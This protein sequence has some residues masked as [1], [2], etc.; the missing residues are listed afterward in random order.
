MSYILIT[1]FTQITSNPY[2]V[3]LTNFYL[4]NLIPFII[5]YFIGIKELLQGSQNDKTSNLFSNLPALGFF[6]L[7]R[8]NPNW[9]SNLFL[10]CILPILTYTLCFPLNVYIYNEEFYGYLIYQ[11]IVWS[12]YQQIF[13]EFFIIILPL[14]LFGGVFGYMIS[15]K[16]SALN[17]SN[18]NVR[19]A[20]K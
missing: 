6:K 10:I 13:T 9:P 18:L 8:V 20:N 5:F 16:T 11:N 12:V 14:S 2:L 19:K 17:H 3:T 15:G 7:R 4:L 1:L